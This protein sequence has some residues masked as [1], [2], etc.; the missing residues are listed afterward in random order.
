MQT[1]KF[2]EILTVWHELADRDANARTLSNDSLHPTPIS[3]EN[4]KNLLQ[5]QLLVL[6]MLLVSD[7]GHSV[8]SQ[9]LARFLRR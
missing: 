3:L 4:E 1:V 5:E 2:G 7:S 6:G 9:C 8:R